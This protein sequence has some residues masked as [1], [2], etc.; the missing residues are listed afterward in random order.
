MGQ[1]CHL[2]VALAVCQ[3]GLKPS[4]NSEKPLQRLIQLAGSFNCLPLGNMAAAV[5]WAFFV[6]L[7]GGNGFSIMA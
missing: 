7:T 5:Q 3:G 2:S 4:A 1:R 6:D